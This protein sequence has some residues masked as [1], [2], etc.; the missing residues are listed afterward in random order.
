MI[1]KNGVLCSPF[2]SHSLTGH[3]GEVVLTVGM[4]FSGHGYCKC[5]SKCTN[6]LLVQDKGR[7]LA[8]CRG[9]IV[10]NESARII[11]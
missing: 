8:V 3:Y 7:Q 6:C 1:K 4:R 10:S 9:S 11:L 5:T 2:V